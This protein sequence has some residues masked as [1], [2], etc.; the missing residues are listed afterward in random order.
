MSYQIITDSCVELPNRLA[1]ELELEVL[2]LRVTVRAKEYAN[3]LDNREI[4]PKAFYDLLRAQN[5]ASTA[6]LNPNDFV[7]VFTPYLKE[8][9][10]ILHLSFSSAL[11]GSYNSALIAQKTLSEEFKDRKIVI[12]DTLA[13]SM[14]EGLLVTLAARYKQSGKTL[15][16]TI[17]YVNDIRLKI[18][19]L[20]TVSDLGHLRRGGRLSA[21]SLVLG[22][23]LNIKPL[24]H[25]NNE[26]QLKVYGKARGRFKS[27]SSLVG[28]MVDTFDKD[29]NDIVYIS[30]GD[31][32]EDAWH[33]R[34]LI[35][36]KLGLKDEQF[37]INN[38]GPVIGAHSGVDTLAIFYLGN[39]RNI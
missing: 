10:D 3:Y 36:E 12:I 25:V 30:H 19:H 7:E 1:K 39:E 6:Q 24:L 31:C 23:L 17:E 21:S 20:F 22:N 35:K 2:P 37:L 15:E 29:L 28:R 18:C 26:G 27:L 32:L 34:D 5:T 8:G 9:K 13:A 4:E 38:I 11:S 16:E 33:V 14:G